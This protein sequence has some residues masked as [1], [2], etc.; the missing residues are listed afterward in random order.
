MTVGP[1]APPANTGL[2]VSA[3]PRPHLQE[4][5]VLR[6]AAIIAVVYLHAYFTPWPEASPRGL[7]AL[8][9]AH[10]IAHGAVPLFLFMAA[11]L[12]AAAGRE[13]LREHLNRRAYSVWL[14]VILWMSAALI[15]R[16]VDQGPSSALWRD[17][18]LFNISGQFYFVWLLLFFGVVFVWADRLPEGSLT[19]LLLAAF[20]VNLVTI[21][22]YSHLDSIGGLL[23]TLAYRNPLAWV[24]FWALGYRLGRAGD[25]HAS[26]TTTVLALAGMSLAAAIYFLRGVGSDSWP[27][28]YFG[29]TV[30]IFSASG[31]LIYPRLA[32]ALL[33]YR[34]VARP[35][36]SL[37]RYAFA[38]YLVHMPLVMGFG[39]KELLGDG[40]AWSNYWVLLHANVAVGLLV[41]L[42]FVREIDKASP[43]LARLALGIRGRA[44]RVTIPGRPRNTS[45]AV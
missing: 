1:A 29:V 3:K 31:L 6:G 43:R 44:A 8:R 16:L 9:G 19:P 5:D 23:S 7:V 42:A 41:S 15:Y 36:T 32:L 35:L 4:F 13:T 14:P 12:Q 33:R 17:L 37:S 30:F 21:G 40:G 20:V 27:V 2:V 45:A 28:S 11:Y 26:G 38:I 34:P 22:W 24:F 18:L 39:T 25:L 10:L